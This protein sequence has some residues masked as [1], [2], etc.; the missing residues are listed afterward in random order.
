MFT[1][2]EALEYM[3]EA[4][5]YG[6]IL[7]L[8]NTKELLKRLGNPQEKLRF[9]HVAGTN[10]KGSI[11]TYIA[12]V[13][14]EAGYKVGR[15]ISPTIFHYRERIQTDGNWITEEAFG[16]N[17]ERIKKAIEQMT[18]EGH[19]HP[20]PF[21]IETAA[22][23]L[24]FLEK[25]CDIVVLEV[26][27]GG[28]L[29]A[30][31]VIETA[32]CGVITSISMDHMGLLGDTIE[33]IAEEKA[34]IIKP[35]MDVVSYNQVEAAQQVLEKHCHEKNASLTYGKPESLENIEYSLEGTR[36]S[37]K[38]ETLG[39]TL[40]LETALLGENQVRNAIVAIEA[41]GVLQRKGY[42]L[43]EKHVI[44]GV[45]KAVWPGRFSLLQKTPYVIV[46][47]AHNE[48]AAISLQKSMQFYFGDKPVTRIIGVFG[49][50]EYE[51]II[52][53]TVKKKDHVY[54]I[55][56]NHERGLASQRLAEVARKYSDT[57]EDGKNLQWA[58][59]KALNEATKDDIILIYGS[60]SYLH[61]V[62]EA[63]G[64]MNENN[65]V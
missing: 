41:C 48:D 25:K 13:L 42:K 54:T 60:L 12:S 40:S 46:D 50:K 55:C 61:E 34:G 31:N 35:G 9:V 44:E 49:D 17:M 4:S 27:L 16:V 39:K 51:K 37:Y 6:M 11:C 47:G 18:G 58:L 63:F 26:G 10:G 3:Q 1:Y 32:E 36:F 59:N 65:G 5:R 52:S 33:K 2:T 8:D 15:Y 62:Y 38:S 57:V 29:D 24:E 20:T 53:N 45:Q 7:G 43:E 23:F 19:P 64:M 21:E 22:A 28:R 56:P 30:T 14:K